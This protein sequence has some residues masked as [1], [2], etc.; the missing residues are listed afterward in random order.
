LKKNSSWKR[1]QVTIPWLG[2]RDRD[3]VA[4]LYFRGTDLG[5][6]ARSKTL[7]LSRREFVAK[8]CIVEQVLALGIA[9]I[10][11]FGLVAAI[12]W[13]AGYGGWRP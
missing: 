8:R 1:M 12:L 7:G 4:G 5:R 6:F 11:A 9:S 13:S 2:A 3:K 10:V